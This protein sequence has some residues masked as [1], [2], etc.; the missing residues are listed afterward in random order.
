M[1]PQREENNKSKLPIKEI[2]RKPLPNNKNWSNTLNIRCSLDYILGIEIYG[3]REYITSVNAF[4]TQ[5]LCNSNVV[6]QGNR[7]IEKGSFNEFKNICFINA[8][9]DKIILCDILE[10]KIDII[11]GIESYVIKFELSKPK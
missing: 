8:R 1:K 7:Y 11:K 5:K 4:S 3:K 2:F 9:N 10:M 6:V